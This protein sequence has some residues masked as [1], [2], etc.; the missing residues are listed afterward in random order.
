MQSQVINNDNF[1]MA[2]MH[3]GT[4]IYSKAKD[5]ALMLGYIDTVKAIATHVDR[6]FKIK[7]TN[8]YK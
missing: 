2:Y 1:N 8:V 5:T 3:P 6:F 4:N 7:L